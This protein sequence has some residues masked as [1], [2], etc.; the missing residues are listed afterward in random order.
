[1]TPGRR[2]AIYTIP[3]S[4]PFVDALA[5]GLFSRHGGDPLEL[6][7]IIVLLPTRRAILGL[8]EA[9]LRLSGR[10]M[11]LPAM[12]PIGDVDEE[13][14]ELT[15]LSGE[16]ALDL[17]PAIEPLHRQLLLTRLILARPD[18]TDEPAQAARLAAELGRLLDQVYTERL[19]FSD[20]A[21]L[22]PA[23]YA[24]HWQVT[25]DFLRIVTENWPAILAERGLID[26]A[27][28][29]DRLI[30]AQAKRWRS[31][32][33]GRPVY[34]AGSTGSLPATAELMR[35]VAGFPEGGVI[36]PGLDTETDADNWAAIGETPTH[37]QFGLHQLLSRL[38]VDR[39]E[40]RE[41]PAPGIEPAAQT[42]VRLIADALRPA[43][44]TDR[45]PDLPAPAA[46]ATEC[47]TR[48]DCPGPHEE[49]GTIALALREV[50][51]TPGRTA[52]L[53]TPDR[54]LGRRVAA[55][56][57]RWGLEID[58][59]GGVPLAH[60][61]P[62]TFLTLTAAMAAE[63]LAPVALL[64]A[65]KHPLAAGGM[66]PIRFRARVREL[67]W[68]VLRG[69]RPAPGFAGLRTAL[70][71][72]NAP[73][74][75]IDWMDRLA[76]AAAPLMDL[77]TAGQADL[78]DLLS[79]HIAFAEWLS[80]TDAEDGL[81]LWA[82]PAGEKA[83]TFVSALHE[84]APV[85]GP[86]AVRSWPSLLEGLM[87]GQA[88]RPVGPLHPRLNLWGPIEARLQRADLVVLGGLNDGTWPPTAQTDPWMS[89]PMR[90][91]FGLPQPERRIGLAAHDF[92]QLAAAPNVLL[93]RATKVDG[94]PTVASRWLL[95]LES[96]LK[97][98]SLSLEAPQ[99]DRY[100]DW[101]QQLDTPPEV[102]QARPPE[103]RPPVKARPCELSVTQIETLIRDPYAIYARHVL[104]LKPLLAVAADPGAADRGTIIHQ[105]LETFVG[106]LPDGPLPDDAEARLIDAGK[107]AFSGVID[108]PAVQAFWWP[109]FLRAGRWFL[110]QEQTRRA[111]IRTSHV[112]VDGTLTVMSGDPSFDLKA[113]ADRIDL[114][115]DGRVEI[116]DYK[117]GGLPS[118]K[119]VE[120]GLS[121]QLSLEAAM[122]MA[123]AFVSIDAA[124]VGALTFMRLGGGEPPGEVRSVKADPEELG[125]EARAKLERLIASYNR[126]STP[127]L[128]RP[129]PMWA[130]RFSDYDHLARVKEWSASGG[131]ET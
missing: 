100:L 102:R 37:G 49:A 51:E 125:A 103:P 60:T 68:R 43:A 15:G 105:A 27:D 64:A 29:R 66:A 96:L 83:A 61:P 12:R 93:T 112:E 4:L 8:R 45:W 62:G 127:Y 53:I 95:R 10:P 24:A 30:A 99:S 31:A 124:S 23:D 126:K 21:D 77:M 74:T 48:I 52:A 63:D 94:T 81:P 32:P 3:P 7:D 2:P 35:L 108:R 117:T 128:S 131:G 25:L 76:A 104:K 84:A 90:T 75:L 14:F 28:R 79:A 59:S 44:T 92:A 73:E 65:L 9:F 20:L 47:L 36:L 26:Q 129:R 87:T 121:P 97:G 38:D 118:D 107:R 123:G 54:D 18:T 82:E 116:L 19:S 55:E 34:L 71:A 13:E 113:K 70:E 57:R 56:L 67:E 80:A 22:V 69:P 109:R 114:M 39:D 115:T 130:S 33:P 72:A 119:Q 41:W 42:R 5:A 122:A 98:A 88:V 101:Q 11:L 16:D 17:P 58:D 40:V 110:E 111:G 91:D 89:R 120:S 86:I 1:M 50:L 85:L 106:G 6:S 78:V 46:A